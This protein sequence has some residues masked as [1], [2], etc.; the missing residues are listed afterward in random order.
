MKV[1]EIIKSG[2]LGCCVLWS[3]VLA[4]MG[5]ASGCT[6]QNE[7]FDSYA[8]GSSMHGQGDWEGW[9]NNP[10]ATAFV[11]QDQALSPLQSVDIKGTAD[12]VQ[13]F[14]ASGGAWSYSAW[15]Y[16]PSDFVSGGGGAFAGSYFFN[17]QLT[18]PGHTFGVFFVALLY[19]AGHFLPDGN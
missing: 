4:G 13:P 3:G 6:I 1:S 15:Q 12:L 19:P 11:R 18:L 9:D 7:N 14:C 10:A 17:N 2:A 8:N 5:E 16:I